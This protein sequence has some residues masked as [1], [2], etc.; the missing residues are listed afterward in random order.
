MIF[1]WMQFMLSSD[2]DRLRKQSTPIIIIILFISLFLV[3][4]TNTLIKN[5]KLLHGIS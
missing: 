2:Q 5:Y 4:Q 1:F 3:S